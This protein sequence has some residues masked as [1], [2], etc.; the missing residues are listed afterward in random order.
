M[1]QPEQVT[2][3][4]P[5]D[6]RTALAAVEFWRSAHRLSRVPVPPALDRAADNLTTLM[7]VNGQC[8]NAS[9]QDWLT[10]DQIAERLRCS[11]RTARRVAAEV[12]KKVGRQWMAPAEALPSED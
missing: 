8:Q 1:G 2:A 7:A 11:V 12:G 5:L 10:T 4:D 9:Q 6:I 3:L